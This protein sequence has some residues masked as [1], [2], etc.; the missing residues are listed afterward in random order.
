MKVSKDRYI[1]NIEIPEEE[2]AKVRILHGTKKTVLE[3][4]K[5]LGA[6]I[7]VNASLFDWKTG[8]PIETFKSDGNTF[9]ESKWVKHGFGVADDQK[10]IIFADFNENFLDYTCGFPTLIWE[11][12]MQDTVL[13]KTVQGIDPRTVFSKGENGYCITTIDGRNEAQG[14]MGM[15]L[16]DAS[17]YLHKKGMW[18]SCNLDGGDSTCVVVDGKVANSPSGTRAIPCVLAFWLKKDEK[19]DGEMQKLKIGLNIGH[20]GTK[21]AVGF[22]DEVV[23]NHSVYD[24]LKP[25]L[26]HQGHT[27]IPL[28][29]AKT[30]DYEYAT[31]LANTKALDIIISLHH[32]SNPD[33]S[34]NGTEVL[35][36][37]S[38]KVGKEYA[39]QLSAKISQALGT[40]NRGAKA[41]N[42]L[43]IIKNTKAPCVI[44]E[45]CFV[46]N[47][48]DC[49][50]WD[51]KKIAGAIASVFGEVEQ[52]NEYEEM[53]ES[54]SKH[55]SISDK[56]GL[57]C[58]MRDKP[59]SRLY[60]MCKKF[61]EY[62]KGD[63]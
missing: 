39:S 14:K 45:S 32:N 58:E 24:A 3:W 13:Y 60:W 19:G 38:S 4:Q 44:V 42:D 46:S 59:N 8:I 2:V 1:T 51:S 55:I 9:G 36:Y 50:K 30:P 54:L 63:K 5:E 23:L 29:V 47:K 57:I 41:R 21:G 33:K 48:E 7:V 37:P 35:H 31:N 62:L 16:D 12:K 49:Q 20:Y 22:L 18:F 40:K 25:F 34:A 28:N 52:K 15:S 53:V 43:Y 17:K 27:V 6:D 10:T 11:G 61:V 26:E 56:Q